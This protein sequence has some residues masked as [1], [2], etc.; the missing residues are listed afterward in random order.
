VVCGTERRLGHR[1]ISRVTEHTLRP[2]RDFSAARSPSLL[3]L[4]RNRSPRTFRSL[5]P[6][7]LYLRQQLVFHEVCGL[8]RNPTFISL[9]LSPI[10]M[11]PN[12]NKT[13]ATLYGRTPAVFT[14]SKGST[15]TLRRYVPI[16]CLSSRP[17]LS[18]IA[19]RHL[20]HPLGGQNS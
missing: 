6:S 4:H 18:T 14:S 3:L 7:T 15:T 20:A 13:T 8:S 12:F 1:P 11:S 16:K 5:T 2:G 10:E 19:L 17:A 9:V